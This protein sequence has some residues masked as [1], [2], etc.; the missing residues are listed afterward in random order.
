MCTGAAEYTREIW[1]AR[2]EK[3]RICGCLQSFDR[4]G[5][6]RFAWHRRWNHTT[7]GRKCPNRICLGTVREK[8][9][10]RKRNGTRGIPAESQSERIDCRLPVSETIELSSDSAKRLVALIST[11]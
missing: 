8:S 1:Q 3:V 5:K 9:R 2:M 6:S 4:L 10:S 7:D 11:S